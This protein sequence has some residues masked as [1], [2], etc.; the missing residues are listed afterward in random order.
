MKPSW[1]DCCVKLNE[2]E[3]FFKKT[4]V[5]LKAMVLSSEM[6]PAKIRLT[7]QVFIEERGAEF[8]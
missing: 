5:K 7:R 8:F 6:F 1:R 2:F 3:S 4:F